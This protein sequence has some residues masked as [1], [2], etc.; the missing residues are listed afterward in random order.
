MATN[1]C[2]YKQQSYKNGHNFSCVRQNH[3]E[4]GFE[5]EFVLFGNSPV[6]LP[7]TRDKEALP[8]LEITNIAVLAFLREITR[9]WLFITG[10]FR[11]RPI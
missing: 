8:W 5:I 2:Q 3:A 4:F 11:G 7:Y 6:T 9:M 10:I 1:F